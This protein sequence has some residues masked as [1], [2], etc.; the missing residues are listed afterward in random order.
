[1]VAEID[2]DLIGLLRQTSTELDLGL[3]VEPADMR[4]P[5]PKIMARQFDT[6]VTDPPYTLDGVN[7]F[8]N[9]AVEAL[10]PDLR[11]RI[12]F[13]YGNSD[14]AREREV[15]IQAVIAEMGL[16]ITQKMPHFNLYEGAESIGSTSSLYLL[17]WTP[18]THTIAHKGSRFY[19]FD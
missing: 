18:K 1:M 15:D 12:Y 5:L 19:S 3:E 2:A 17:D 7:L 14:R 11:S 8:L 9:R 6:V 10:A 13:C 16:R 4:K